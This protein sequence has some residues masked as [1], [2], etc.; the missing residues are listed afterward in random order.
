MT[1]RR[2]ASV[3]DYRAPL[4][5]AWQL[6][7]RCPCRCLHCCEDSG[8]REAWS[9]ELSKDEALRVAADCARCAIPYVV[10]GGGEPLGVAH[11]WDIFETLSKNGAAVKIE[12]DGTM[13]DEEAAGRLR[14]LSVDC[15]QVSVDG[16]EASTHERI[17]PG[18]DFRKAAAAI[19]RLA[20]RGVPAEFVFVPCRLNASEICGAYDLAAKLGA[21][22]FVTGPMM[23]LG[24]A[25]RDWER[26]SLSRGE[27]ARAVEEVEER[28]LLRGHPIRL[29]I[30][31]WDI[32]EET[33]VRLHS[34]QA[35]LLAVPDG[36]VKLLNALPFACADL[37]KQSLAEAWDACQAA[38]KSGEVSGF[39]RRIPL[40]PELLKHANETWALKGPVL[41]R[42]NLR[43]SGSLDA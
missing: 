13:I 18:G 1:H 33:Q 16:A 34:P 35:M 28:A 17:R 29:S 27:W 3:G 25:A 40:E 19:E 2:G 15:V 20:A 24:R 5:L 31:P 37:R 39:V 21:R 11:A 36:R 6:T 41:N 9:A 38:W 4:L 26:L 7:N 8:P 42:P 32:V 43:R 23:R 14:S 22:T 30:Y 12:T 10:F